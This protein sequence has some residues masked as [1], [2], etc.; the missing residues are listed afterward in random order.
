MVPFSGGRVYAAALYSAR[1]LCTP[2]WFFVVAPPPPFPPTP[3]PPP[4]LSL[5]VPAPNTWGG[6]GHFYCCVRAVLFLWL[7]L[8]TE[9]LGF[10]SF[11]FRRRLDSIC[12][13]QCVAWLCVNIGVTILVRSVFACLSF[14]L[15]MLDTC[16]LPPW[17][18]EVIVVVQ[19]TK[20]VT[21]T[22]SYDR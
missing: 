1:I 11:L 3:L 21:T 7:I 12:P 19:A 16:R 22:V 5:R 9:K 10:F 13:F 15:L 20:C 18:C 2:A 14:C 17:H 4:P 6:R 8:R